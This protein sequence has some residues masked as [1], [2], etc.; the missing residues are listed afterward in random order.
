MNALIIKSLQ[1]QVFGRFNGTILLDDEIVHINDLL[2]FA[3]K[4]TNYW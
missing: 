2:G 4:V 1:N 3:E